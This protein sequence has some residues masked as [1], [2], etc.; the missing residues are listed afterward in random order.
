[1]ED[2]DA[3]KK[4]EQELQIVITTKRETIK[5]IQAPNLRAADK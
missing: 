4:K 2:L 1:M 5:K 3:I